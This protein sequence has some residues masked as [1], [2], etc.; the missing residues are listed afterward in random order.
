ME[1]EMRCLVFLLLLPILTSAQK[2]E[3]RISLSQLSASKSSSILNTNKSDV[4][5]FNS[6]QWMLGYNRILSNNY[7]VGFNTGYLNPKR[8]ATND[9]FLAAQNGRSTN[10]NVREYKQYELNMF[11]GKLIK[12]QRIRLYSSLGVYTNYKWNDVEDYVGTNY[13]SLGNKTGEGT[14]G[15]KYPHTLNLGLFIQQSISYPLYKKIYI[16]AELKELFYFYRTKGQRIFYEKGYDNIA[17][18][19]WDITENYDWNNRG[20]EFRFLPHI[21]L[22]FIF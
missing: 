9:L 17:Q 12:Y 11:F 5:G 21:G 7:F 1:K 22:R 15:N 6:V 20:L 8:V 14:F 16:C 2:H 10:E 19:T 3:L 4:A 13:D 18:R